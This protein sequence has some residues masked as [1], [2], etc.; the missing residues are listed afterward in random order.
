MNL[1]EQHIENIKQE[2]AEAAAKV[3]YFKTTEKVEVKNYPY[4]RLRTS[5]FFG[6]EHRPGKGFRTTFQTI[7]PKTG[8][9]NKVKYSTYGPLRI[10]Q[11]DHTGRIDYIYAQWYDDKDKRNFL[12]LLDQHF[13]LFTAEQIEDLALYI[14][15]MTKVDFRS[16][17]TY[18][19]K[20]ENHTAAI[21]ILKEA[22][23]EP[24][25]ILV[26]IAK[27][28]VNRFGEVL[29]KLDFEKIRSVET[30]DYSPFKTTEF[31]IIGDNKSEY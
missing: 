12:S 29:N 15:A 19:V 5:A 27:N 11:Q 30:P 3:E 23:K 26:D 20:P 4:G 31:M 28:K 1:F 14:I 22:Y 7:N 13:R 9:L 21:E 16:I 24:L 8:K 2:A 17:L 6:L 10:M 25:K 18:C